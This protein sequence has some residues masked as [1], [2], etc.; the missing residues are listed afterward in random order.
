VTTGAIRSTKLQS[1]RHHQRTNTNLLV[2]VHW[3]IYWRFISSSKNTDDC[4]KLINSNTSQKKTRANRR[5]TLKSACLSGTDCISGLPLM[6]FSIRILSSS[7]FFSASCNVSVYCCCQWKI[8]INTVL[9]TIINSVAVSFPPASEKLCSEI[10]RNSSL[11][12][13]G[14]VV[15]V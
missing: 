8:I 7:A 10:C 2:L 6:I 5:L 11:G 12:D 3:F 9:T 13:A 15:G 1:N 4:R 14:C